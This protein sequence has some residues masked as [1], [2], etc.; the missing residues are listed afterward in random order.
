MIKLES[1]LCYIT[2]FKAYAVC[3]FFKINEFEECV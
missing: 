3:S 1:S 2:D